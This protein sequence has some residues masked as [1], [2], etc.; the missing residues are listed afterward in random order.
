MFM[1]FTLEPQLPGDST[2][3][4]EVLVDHVQSISY[5]FGHLFYRD[6][7]ARHVADGLRLIEAGESKIERHEDLPKIV[8]WV[9]TYSKRLRKT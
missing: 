6:R 1:P 2:P 5:K 4:E 8:R 3:Y 7:V 9:N